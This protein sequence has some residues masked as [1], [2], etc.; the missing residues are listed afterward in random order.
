MIWSLIWVLVKGTLA[1][2]AIVFLMMYLGMRAV[3]VQN[4]G[5][6]TKARWTF[7]AAVALG[8]VISLWWGV[9]SFLADYAAGKIH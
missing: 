3:D 9:E 1:H 6:E 4:R 7:A 5:E 2:G 8:L